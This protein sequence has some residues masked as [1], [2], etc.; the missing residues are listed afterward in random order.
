VRVVPLPKVDARA[1]AIRAA[2]KDLDNVSTG[3]PNAPAWP[4]T[5]E[6]VLEAAA[7]LSAAYTGDACACCDEFVGFGASCVPEHGVASALF[8]LSEVPPKAWSAF[9]CQ[10]N[11]HPELRAQYDVSGQFAGAADQPWLDRVRASLL[12]PRGVVTA[13]GKPKLRLC[14]ACITNLRNGTVPEFGLVNGKCAAHS[15]LYAVRT[16]ARS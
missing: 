6:R 2:I 7:L 8:A 11:L 4:L 9:C 1:D 13:A 14:N 16:S 15:R 5:R 10:G 12:S 3:I